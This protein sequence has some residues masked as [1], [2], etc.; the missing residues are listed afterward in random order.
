MTK[1][2]NGAAT[3]AHIESA[4]TQLLRE[5]S[6]INTRFAEA[7]QTLRSIP[8]ALEAG[9]QA[10]AARLLTAATDIECDL[11][12]DTEATSPLFDELGL[13]DGAAT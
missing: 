1:R 9:D 2:A 7:I 12:G 6:D 10:E 3:V 4:V 5:Q 8:S 13:D 11:T